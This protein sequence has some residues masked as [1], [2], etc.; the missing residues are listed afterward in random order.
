MKVHRFKYCVLLLFTLLVN[1]QKENLAEKLGYPSDSK[2]L[3]LHADDIGVAQ[4]VNQ[5]S[6]N[7]F[8]SGSITSGSVMVPCPWFLEAA[9]Y[10]KANPNHDLGLHLTVTSEW[11]NYKWGGISSSNE[12]NSLIN[13]NGHF[14]ESNNDFEENAIYGEVKK[15]LKAQVNYAIKNGLNPTHLDSHM[16]ALRSR[17]DTYQAYIEIGQEFDIPVLLSKEYENTISINDVD[18]SNIDI[19][20]LIWVNK[21]YSKTDDSSIDEESWEKFYYDTL[22]KI[23]PG[24]NVMLLHLGYDNGELK[25][26]MVDH[27]NWGSKWRGLDKKIIESKRFRNYLNDKKIILVSFNQINKIL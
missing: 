19:S 13:N 1:A 27:P 18:K 14:Y 9:E 7:A 16:G 23:Q 8:E 17:L 4:S 6:F 3:I 2:L 26:M 12:I 20:K 15:E 5:A 22:D 10:A 11:K 25:S 21:I 24:L